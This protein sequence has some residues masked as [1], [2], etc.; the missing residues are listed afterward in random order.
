ML[1]KHIRKFYHTKQCKTIL[2]ILWQRCFKGDT[3]HQQRDGKGKP[4]MVTLLNAGEL[5]VT[6]RTLQNAIN[7]QK[8]FGGWLF[9]DKVHLM[10]SDTE[11]D[12]FSYMSNFVLENS[13]VIGVKK[14]SDG[15]TEYYG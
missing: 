12:Y 9:E 8:R 15:T 14:Y 13:D 11:L 6:V 7:F 4:N 5:T 1:C 2:L 3:I 10:F